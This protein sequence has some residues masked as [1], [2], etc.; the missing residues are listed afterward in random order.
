MT[1]SPERTDRRAGLIVVGGLPA[2]GKT[3]IA[4]PL[5]SS[6]DAA[7]LRIDTIE[8]AIKRS[9]EV[10]KLETVGYI[11]GYA[12][13]RDQLRNGL[14]CVTECVNPI[15]L[16]RDAW[17]EVALEEGAWLLDVEVTC[18]DST[19]HRA[20]VEGRID[21]LQTFPVSS[22]RPGNKWSTASMNRGTANVS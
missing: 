20:R 3:S 21:A 8:S 22:F 2:T 5:A 18:S 9:G 12:L 6:L 7:Y 17:R 4:R 14:L 13:A 11:V 19:Q 10:P 16:T 1:D 15:K